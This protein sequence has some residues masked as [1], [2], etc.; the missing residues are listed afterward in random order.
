L[1]WVDGFDSW[2]MGGSRYG[3]SWDEKRQALLE[4]LPPGLDEME[5]GD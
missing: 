1:W 4:S 5:W 2:E 3:V